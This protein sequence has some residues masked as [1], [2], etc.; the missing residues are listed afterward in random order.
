MAANAGISSTCGPTT[1][2][3]PG[4]E[5]LARICVVIPTT[6]IFSPFLSIITEG[7]IPFFWLLAVMLA[8][9]LNSVSRNLWFVYK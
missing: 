5:I 2:V 6:P 8:A 3:A 9:V 7:A 1:V 4:D